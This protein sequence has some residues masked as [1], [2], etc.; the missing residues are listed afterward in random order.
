MPCGLSRSL[1]TGTAK[2]RG[3]G[4]RALGRG[5]VPCPTPPPGVSWLWHTGIPCLYPLRPWAFPLPCPAYIHCPKGAR[6]GRSWLTLVSPPFS[7]SWRGPLAGVA[8]L[9][10][11]PARFCRESPARA[12]PL[13]LPCSSEMQAPTGELRTPLALPASAWPGLCLARGLPMTA[14]MTGREGVGYLA[15][16]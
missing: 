2:A 5:S 3:Q 15:H 9:F 8:Q 13:Q 1:A 16:P 6:S 12:H 14:M 7:L 4:H 10:L 11:P